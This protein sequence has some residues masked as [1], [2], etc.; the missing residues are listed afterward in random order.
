MGNKITIETIKE[1]VEYGTHA[2]SGDNSQPWSFRFLNETLY[3]YV[4]P[5]KDTSMYNFEQQ[6]S[7]VAIGAMLENI[8]I[9]SSHF[10]YDCLIVFNE[11]L[12]DNLVAQASFIFS[13]IKENEF[14]KWI[15]ERKT[16][17]KPYKTEK[18][19][20]FVINE[21]KKQEKDFIS[22]GLRMVSDLKLITDISLAC[23]FNEKIVLE[24]KRLH[25]FL[26]NHITWNKQED[27][28]KK[29]FFLDTLELDGPK[30]IAFK[31]LKN[32]RLNNFLNI[33]GISKLVASD[34]QRVYEQSALIIGFTSKNNKNFNF[35]ETGMLMQRI[36]LTLTK[37]GL[38]AQPLTG[39]TLLKNR[40]IKEGSDVSLSEKH[41][42]IVNESY[43]TIVKNLSVVDEF[44]TVLLRVGFA[45]PPSAST[46][47]S[48]VVI[49]V[50]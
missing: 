37:Y 16:N 47:R 14:F 32:W 3:I 1:I 7:L 27:D 23:S 45:E 38:F 25:D 6:A 28:I 36:W 39:I 40:I 31:I 33:F 50:E 22:V 49:V 10:G 8:K 34:N 11:S 2:P 35:I 26:F 9:S 21:F 42:S 12:S 48:S 15:K 18:I 17:R 29:G 4:L 5:E 30:K 43:N 41:T 20:E 44:V 46:Q 24:D 13:D 19:P